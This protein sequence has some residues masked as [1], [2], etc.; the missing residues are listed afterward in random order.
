MLVDFGRL[1]SFL[2]LAPI[3]SHEAVLTQSG[4]MGISIGDAPGIVSLYDLF[5]TYTV[6]DRNENFRIEQITNGSFYIGKESDGKVAIYAI[7][8]V[9]RLTLISQWKDMTN[10]ILFPGSYIRFDPSRNRSLNNA[11][12]FRTI[13]SLKDTDGEV[14]EFVNP[15]VN[16]GDEQDTFFN[17]RLPNTSIRL[18]RA[19]SAKFKQKVDA[20]N[21]LREKYSKYGYDEGIVESK[22]LFNPSKKNHNMLVELG[23]LLARALNSNSNSNDIIGKIWTI[24]TQATALDVQDSTAKSLVEQFLLDWR[25]AQYGWSVN[26]KYRDTYEGIAWIIWVKRTDARWEL[27]QNLADIYSRNLFNQKSTDFIKSI[28]TYGPTA[29][30]LVKTL[31]R[32]EIPQKDYFDIAIYA[33]N[34]LKK[35]EEKS[36]ILWQDTMEEVSTYTYF[37]TFFR[38]SNKY[39]ESITDVKKREDTIMSFSRQFYDSILTLLVNS[40]YSTY[41][42][43]EDGGLFLDPNYRESIE[44]KIPEDVIEGIRNLNATVEAV[45]P[46]IQSVWSDSWKTDTD[47]YDRINKNII[48]LKAFV[49]LIDPESYKDYIK[50]PYKVHSESGEVLFP[51]I[52]PDTNLIVRLDSKTVEKI[53]NIK[54]LAIDPRI[55]ELRK[56]WPD[57]GDTSLSIEWD[58]IRIEKAPYKINRS[59]EGI[60]SIELS[61]LYKDK[62]LTDNVIYYGDY[63]IRIVTETNKPLSLPEYNALLLEVDSYLDFIDIEVT[64]QN[65]EV[66]EMRIFPSKQRINIGDSIFPVS[67]K[68]R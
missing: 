39:I 21:N 44:V 5:L 2:Y 7:D 38:A 33:F 46:S 40:L 62:R 60:S 30:E 35:M 22:W 8:G 6:Y 56:I 51:L 16:I 25:F 24:Y 58:N 20:K 34:I 42:V 26:A 31:D 19:L 14:F 54:T 3:G 59:W 1:S 48:R 28:D 10:L 29:N 11:D 43:A 12:L 61:A 47:A 55:Q 18:F 37:T 17:Y 27:F 64:A 63:I 53:K 50:T 36:Q 68:S 57:A 41:I 4:T 49:T 66:G 52:D 65:R 15:R 13:L 23:S 32:N 67:I 45:T 9:I